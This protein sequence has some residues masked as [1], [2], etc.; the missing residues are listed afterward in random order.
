MCAPLV[1]IHELDRGTTGMAQ[2]FFL[3]VRVWFVL[4][5]GDPLWFGFPVVG[6]DVL[7]AL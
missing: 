7:G 1:V 6:V 2:C 5:A 4:T 3:R